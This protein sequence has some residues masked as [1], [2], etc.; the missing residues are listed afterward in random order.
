LARQM[1][2]IRYEPGHLLWSTGDLST[3]SLHID[4]GR[5][6][7]TAPDGRHVDVGSG[8][9]IGVMDVWGPRR[10]AYEARTETAVIGYRIE[11]ESFLTLLESH[12]EVGLEVL[13]GFARTLLTERTSK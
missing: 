4:C 13:R 6:R 9:N 8:F 5:V 3:H 1:V 10:R 11:F 7:C 2:E 12:V